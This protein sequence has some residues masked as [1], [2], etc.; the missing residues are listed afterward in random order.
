MLEEN[1][2]VNVHDLGLGNELLDMTPK[3]QSK[4]N[5]RINKL[6]FIKIKHFYVS[7]DIIKKVNDI[8]TLQDMVLAVVCCCL[9]S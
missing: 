8:G 6:D 2:G 7:K 4:N 3:A 1:I 5:K 9:Q